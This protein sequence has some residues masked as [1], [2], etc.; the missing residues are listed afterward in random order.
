MR[1]ISNAAKVA[2]NMHVLRD[3]YLSPV[4]RS[5]D[6]SYP[7]HPRFVAFA[8]R[9][10]GATIFGPYTNTVSLR[11]RYGSTG[12]VRCLDQSAFEFWRS[13]TKGGIGDREIEPIASF[14]G[15]EDPLF[16]SRYRMQ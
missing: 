2:N 5:R 16:L 12:W 15:F 3:R 4:V 10:R 14:S 11:G 7:T 8:S 13:G 1:H 9:P 6:L